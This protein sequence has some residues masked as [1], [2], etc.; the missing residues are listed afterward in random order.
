MKIERCALKI[1][2]DTEGALLPTGA[3]AKFQAAYL[4]RW[5]LFFARALVTSLFS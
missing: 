4:R 1:E 2:Y 5:I 3:L